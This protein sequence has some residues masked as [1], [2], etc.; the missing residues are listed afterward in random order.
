MKCE[1]CG[2]EAV[3]FGM[4][5]DKDFDWEDNRKYIQHPFCEKHYED[6]VNNEIEIPAER[7]KILE[8]LSIQYYKGVT[9]NPD[10]T[11]THTW[12]FENNKGE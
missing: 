6:W 9:E 12:N 4:V 3:V 7:L 8:A 10:G 5:E 2:E 11:F 1:V